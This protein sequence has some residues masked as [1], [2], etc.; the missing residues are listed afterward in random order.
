MINQ[1]LRNELLAMRE[2]DLR[3]RGELDAAGELGGPYVP[4]MEAV[5]V[6]NAARL[7]ELIA[8]YGWPAEDIAGEESFALASSNVFRA[9][10]CACLARRLSRRSNC[11]VRRPSSAL[12]DA[13]D[14]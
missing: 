2:E 6:R 9:G 7:R 1:S 5:H 13:M 10:P 8:Q 3:V 11:H 12:R 14:G 4:R